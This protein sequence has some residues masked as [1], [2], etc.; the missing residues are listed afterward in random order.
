MIWTNHV[1]TK[2][3]VFGRD[4]EWRLPAAAARA[5]KA[6]LTTSCNFIMRFYSFVIK[7]D[8]WVNPRREM[9]LDYVLAVMSR[10]RAEAKESRP[11]EW[12]GR[13]PAALRQEMS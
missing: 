10:Q 12:D 4:Q 5:T 1:I 7:F 2:N 13:T 6:P 9:A 8:D 3:N 11:I